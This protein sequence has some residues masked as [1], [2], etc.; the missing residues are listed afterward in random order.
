MV[1]RDIY[2]QL[3]KQKKTRKEDEE[4]GREREKRR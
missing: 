1:S 4:N 2:K 3:I